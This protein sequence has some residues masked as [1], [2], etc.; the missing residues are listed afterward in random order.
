MYR[1]SFIAYPCVA[2]DKVRRSPSPSYRLYEL[3]AELQAP[4]SLRA[5]CSTS[6]Q[7]AC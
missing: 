7:P 1:S 5:V 2:F 4:P 6:R 3:E